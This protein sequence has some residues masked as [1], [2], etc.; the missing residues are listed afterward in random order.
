MFLVTF[1]KLVPKIWQVQ[2]ILGFFIP[3]SLSIL[4]YKIFKKKPTC[5]YSIYGSSLFPFSKDPTMC[6]YGVRMCTETFYVCTYI[7]YIC[8]WEILSES[9][10]RGDTMFFHRCVGIFVQGERMYI[11]IW[12]TLEN[13]FGTSCF[14]GKTAYIQRNGIRQS[15]TSVP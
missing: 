10:C 1:T 8:G 6:G 11:Q 4:D 14:G 9:G 13:C 12:Y 15:H 7:L 5:N 2:E 3:E